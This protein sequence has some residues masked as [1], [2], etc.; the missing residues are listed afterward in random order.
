MGSLVETYRKYPNAA[1]ILPA[2]GYG[3][4]QIRD[5]EATIHATPADVVVEGTPIDLRRVLK[6]GKPMVRVTYELAE[7]EPGAL[8]AEIRRTLG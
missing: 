2:M 7:M 1:G 5:L 6:P 4:A 3:E 8:E